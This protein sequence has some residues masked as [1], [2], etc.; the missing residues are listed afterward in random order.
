MFRILWEISLLIHDMSPP[1]RWVVW[2]ASPHHYCHDD[3]LFSALTMD[4]PAPDLTKDFVVLG[5][6]EIVIPVQNHPKVTQ[7]LLKDVFYYRTDKARNIINLTLLQKVN[8]EL[9]LGKMK[10]DHS[11]G[12]GIVHIDEPD[13]VV[14]E[15]D[16]FD[17]AR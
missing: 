13:L 4:L 2:N 8:P 15:V 12:T 6:G 17:E 11:H 1:E 16:E 3:S 14:L 7:I 5:K 9:V 10:L